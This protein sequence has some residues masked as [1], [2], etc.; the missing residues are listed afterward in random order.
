M[1]SLLIPAVLITLVFFL[2]G[3]EKIYRFPMSTSKFAKKVGL[4]LALGQLVIIGAIALE[5]GAPLIISA[6]IYTKNSSLVPFFK[7][8]VGALMAFTLMATVLYHNPMK[9]RDSY[10]SFMSDISTFGGL[11]ALYLLA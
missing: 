6:Y 3:F 7:L 9:S 5:L 8:S 4:P 1:Q 10:Y 11:W 2:S